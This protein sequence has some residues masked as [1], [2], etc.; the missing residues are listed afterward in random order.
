MRCM[1]LPTRNVESL[2]LCVCLYILYILY[3]LYV[4]IS[5]IYCISCMSV[6]LAR[7]LD[8]F[9]IFGQFKKKNSISKPILLNDI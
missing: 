7:D 2:T 6:Y 4:C 5:S 3:S 9:V 8:K 1:L